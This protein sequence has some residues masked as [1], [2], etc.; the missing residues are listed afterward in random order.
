MITTTQTLAAGSPSPAAPPSAGHP[1][2]CGGS[3][4]VVPPGR[5]HP[6]R[7]QELERLARK[8]A[9]PATPV[10]PTGGGLGAR[11]LHT[12]ARVRW[13]M[14]VEAMPGD[15]PAMGRFYGFRLISCLEGDGHE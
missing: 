4:N 13:T 6:E 5:F 2:G 8:I 3:E 7:P 10:S 12:G 9:V 15:V 1:S 11:G 14:T